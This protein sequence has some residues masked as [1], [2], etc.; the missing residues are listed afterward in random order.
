MSI[1]IKTNNAA[2]LKG[3]LAYLGVGAFMHLLFAGIHLDPSSALTWAWLFAW[4]IL[5]ALKALRIFFLLVALGMLIGAGFLAS[6]RQY[7]A[8]IFPIGVA[9]LIAI[10]LI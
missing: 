2:T 1:V 6:E 9:C 5:L 10:L 3:L 7:G 4:P 8:A